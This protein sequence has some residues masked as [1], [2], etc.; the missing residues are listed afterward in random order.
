MN[1]KLARFEKRQTLSLRRIK[2]AFGFI[3]S[4][5]AVRGF[6]RMATEQIRMTDAIGKLQDRLGGTSEAWSE[7]IFV[8]E[9]AG[10]QQNQMTLGLQRMIRRVAEAADGFGEAQGALKTLGL[11]AEKLTRLPFD[12]QFEIIAQRLSEVDEEGR[13][14][15][16]AMKLFDSEGVKLVQTMTDGAKGIREV[17]EEARQ[18]GASLSQD[19]VDAATRAQ[20]AMT[21]LDAQLDAMKRNIVIGL[22]P[23]IEDF[24]TGLEKMFNPSV[25]QRAAE[26]QREIFALNQRL[27]FSNE[28]EPIQAQLR[29]RLFELQK[30][31]EALR[32]QAADTADELETVIEGPS[33]SNAS[34]PAAAVSLRAIATE[35]E[36]LGEK[37]K[38][39]PGFGTLTPATTADEIFPVGRIVDKATESMRKAREE[40]EKSIDAAQELGFVFESAFENAIVNGMKLR[41]VLKGILQDILRIIIRQRVT[42]PLAGALLKNIPVPGRAMGGP[43]TAGSPFIVGEKGPELFV[44]GASGNIMPNS[45]LGGPRFEFNIDASGGDADRFIGLVPQI[46]QEAA[47]LTIGR[48]YDLRAKGRF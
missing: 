40:T 6:A 17:R 22:L 29:E 43:V 10:I 44:P 7:L 37:L 32:A 24:N 28:P 20:D 23:A 18:L 42:K 27:K 21:N 48:M 9:R 25:A 26:L 15:A 5:A 41:D 3:I 45:A 11:D 4:G 31:L 35:A 1:R 46:M 16:L 36:N 8:G 47:D 33:G 19:T 39:L 13:R 14:T 38:E 34:D 2:Q 12:Q 30:E